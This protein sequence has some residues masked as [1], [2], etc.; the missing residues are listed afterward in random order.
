MNASIKNSANALVENRPKSCTRVLEA[1]DIDKYV[2]TKIID[3]K[4][5]EIM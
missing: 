4:I 2:E 5:N 1:V 3:N